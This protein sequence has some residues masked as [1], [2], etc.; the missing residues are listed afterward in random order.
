MRILLISVFLFNT[1]NALWAQKPDAPFN[2]FELDA[3][4]LIKKNIPYATSI[5][6]P[7]PAKYNIETSLSSQLDLL[8]SYRPTSKTRITSGIGISSN[9]YSYTFKDGGSDNYYR[10]SYKVGV[11][12]YKI[13]LR[14]NYQVYRSV[15]LMTGASFNFHSFNSYS[16]STEFGGTSPDTSSMRYLINH[17]GFLDYFTCSGNL[18]IQI[19]P[20][21]KFKFY[22]IG[23]IDLGRS[24]TT[25]LE[26]EI[27]KYGNKTKYIAT[28]HSKF[29][30][31]SAG[32]SY[33]L[34]KVA[35]KPVAVK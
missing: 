5:N 34:F 2:R 10:W 20:P 13:P 6:Q 15:E 17:G 16:L 14:F 33:R 11:G 4:L 24:L 30:F 19:S 29:M 23:D 12:T 26:T 18:G 27:E 31:V 1:L 9:S 22:L 3:A 25:N 35:A 21:G 7:S 32:L 28:A 8:I